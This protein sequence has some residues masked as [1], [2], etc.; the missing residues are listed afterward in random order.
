MT[1]DQFGIALGLVLGVLSGIALGAYRV[2]RIRRSQERLNAIMREVF[3]QDIADTINE[4]FPLREALN[5]STE[6][7]SGHR[8]YYDYDYGR[9]SE[10][11]PEGQERDSA[12]AR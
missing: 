11:Q 12:Q 9:G 4:T 10:A 2:W 7:K 8:S 1:P 3:E 6:D 5:G